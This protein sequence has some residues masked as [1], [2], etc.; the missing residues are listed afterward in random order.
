MEEILLIFPKI[1]KGQSP[2][3]LF[4]ELK[5]KYQECEILTHETIERVDEY[6]NPETEE[7]YRTNSF[8]P[9]THTLYI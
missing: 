1:K 5:N 9:Q 7:F 8:A 2:L 4:F 6:I 3:I